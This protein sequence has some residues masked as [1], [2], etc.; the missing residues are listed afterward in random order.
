VI[1]T[2]RKVLGVINSEL[3]MTGHADKALKVLRSAPR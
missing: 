2:D 3:D 1:G